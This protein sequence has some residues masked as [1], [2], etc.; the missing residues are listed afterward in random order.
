DCLLLT[1]PEVEEAG[2]IKQALADIEQAIAK[3]IEAPQPTP[4]LAT[5]VV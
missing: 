1:L 3:A 5:A 4:E 2:S